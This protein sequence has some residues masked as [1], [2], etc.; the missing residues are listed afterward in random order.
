LTIQEEG[1]TLS[2]AATSINFVGEGVTATNVAEAITVTVSAG[3]LANLDGGTPST[4]YGGITAINAG[5]P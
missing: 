4:N 5:T 3:T 2:S 1:T